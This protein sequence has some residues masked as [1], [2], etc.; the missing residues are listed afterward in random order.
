M[1]RIVAN[2]QVLGVRAFAVLAA[3]LLALGTG[4]A[5]APGAS[6]HSVL[7]SA[8]PADGSSLASAPSEVVLTF[9]EPI[10]TTTVQ[11]AVTA[12]TGV[13][14][15]TEKATVA[16]AVI[17]L[18]LPANLPND[19]YT[20]AYRVISVDGHPVQASVAFSVDNPSAT[21]EPLGSN[22]RPYQVGGSTKVAQGETAMYAKVLYLLVPV[23]IGVLLL[24]LIKTRGR[25]RERNPKDDGE[26]MASPFI[27]P[28]ADAGQ[29]PEPTEY[30]HT[31]PDVTRD[32]D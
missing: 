6:A 15:N 29:R 9:N 22:D 13:T 18:K 31:R 17:T 23:L 10:Q 16:G 25:Y 3:L 28:R 32:R 20:V 24:G 2:R 1:R 14:A 27:L 5:L 11:M 7:L 21:A 12:S 8:V 26:G 30:V 19:E 4:L